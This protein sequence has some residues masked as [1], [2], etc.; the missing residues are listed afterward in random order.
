MYFYLRILLVISFCF[1]CSTYKAKVSGG[2]K[3][4]ENVDLTQLSLVEKNALANEVVLKSVRDPQEIKLDEILKPLNENIK[5]IGI[6]VFETEIQPTRS[7]L[8][9]DRSIYLNDVSKALL[10]EQMF[11]VFQT[12]LKDKLINV[13]IVSHEEIVNTK[14]NRLYGVEFDYP[15]IDEDR[16]LGQDNLF[17]LPAGKK[18]TMRSVFIPKGF[19]D[20]SIVLVPAMELMHGPKVVEHQKHFINDLSKE[21]NLDALLVISSKVS[22]TRKGIDKRTQEVIQEEIKFNQ[23]LTMHYP[24]GLY[25]KKLISKNKSLINKKSIPI[26]TLEINHTEPI[27]ISVPEIEENYQT[28]EN[29]FLNPFQKRYNELTELLVLKLSNDLNG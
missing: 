21:L 5:R 23:T 27:K 29:N 19:Q 11:K 6:A 25:E 3:N 16:A 28:I 2:K 14:A 7:G 13:E 22:W 8:T 15:L 20:L 24:F 1:S 10:T 9:N 17:Y 26:L 4:L 18:T 12:Q